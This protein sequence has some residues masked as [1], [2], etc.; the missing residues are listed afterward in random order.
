MAAEACKGEVP[1]S[2]RPILVRPAAND[3]MVGMI[4]GRPPLRWPHT[5]RHAQGQAQEPMDDD[6]EASNSSDAGNADDGERWQGGLGRGQVNVDDSDGLSSSFASSCHPLDV[7]PVGI[8]QH[9]QPHWEGTGAELFELNTPIF[10]P[11][12]PVIGV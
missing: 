10:K 8:D 6:S 5:S 11:H 4:A 1:A 7:E 2:V 9:P 12:T 3:V